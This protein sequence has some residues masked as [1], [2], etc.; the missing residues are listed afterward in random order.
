MKRYLYFIALTVPVLFFLN[1]WIKPLQS[2]NNELADPVSGLSPRLSEFDRNIL[3]FEKYIYSEIEKSGTVGAALV[4]TRDNE[5]I[6]LKCYGV[7]KA[8]ENEPVDPETRFRLASVSKTITGTLAGI[9]DGK[10]ILKLDEKIKDII[11]GFRLKDSVNTADLSIR[12]ILS[13]TSGLVPHAYDNLVEAGLPFDV[14]MDSLQRVNI[15][16]PPGIL[17]GYQNLVFSLYDTLS[18]LKTGKDFSSLLGEYLFEPLGMQHSGS[19]YNG[20]TS[21]GNIAY[22]HRRS[23]TAFKPLKMNNRYY[24]TQPAAGISTSIS[25]L[26]IFLKALTGNDT[27]ALPAQILDTVFSP[28]VVTPLRRNYLRHWDPVDSRHYSLGWRIIGYKGRTIA[29]HGGYIQGYRAEIAVCLEEKTGIAF[30][31]N[32]PGNVASKVVPEFLNRYFDMLDDPEY[33]EPGQQDPPITLVRE[34]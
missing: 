2:G 10:G 18:S 12:H 20:F 23:G 30:L 4:I 25:D 21:G 11:P 5:T 7:R 29:Y 28:Q 33:V 32:S 3:E 22:P 9:L 26:G 15:S 19:G 31:S 34:Y 6:L 24:N 1:Y 8:G 27:V 17:Y 13:H 14:L 16:A